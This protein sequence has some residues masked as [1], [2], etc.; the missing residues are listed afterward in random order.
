MRGGYKDV[1]HGEYE[2]DQQSGAIEQITRPSAT[3]PPTVLITE[4][5]NGT[6]ILQGRPDGPRVW[7]NPDEAVP[8]KRELAAAFGRNELAVAGDDQGEAW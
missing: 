8:L 3:T 4:L 1:Q 7:L 5:D 6:L 2:G